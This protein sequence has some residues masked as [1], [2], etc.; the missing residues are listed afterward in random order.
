[1]MIA[2][3]DPRESERFLFCCGGYRRWELV[4]GDGEWWW[5]LASDW[6]QAH[7]ADAIVPAR[8]RVTARVDVSRSEAGASPSHGS[9]SLCTRIEPGR[10][11]IDGLPF[12]ADVAVSVGLERGR[13]RL[14]GTDVAEACVW[15]LDEHHW[16]SGPV[17]LCIE[18]SDTAVTVYVGDESIGT[19]ALT[20]A[21]PCLIMVSANSAGVPEAGTRFGTLTVE[22]LA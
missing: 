9:V 19:A 8:S 18:R 15:P 20:A 6:G 21:R 4:E 14:G 22:R 17:N 13:I 11:G 16:N 2:S 1:M 12:Q 3:F 5:R 7:I 10:L